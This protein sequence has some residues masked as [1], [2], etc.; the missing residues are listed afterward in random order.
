MEI[1]VLVTS[2]RTV[3]QGR[4][5]E[6]GKDSEDYL[7]N[8]ALIELSEEDLKK[9]GIEEGSCVRVE[10]KWGSIVVRCKSSKNLPEGVAFMPYGP[11][12]SAIAD[13][14]TFGV[15]IPY[16]KQ[17]ECTVSPAPGEKVPSLKELA[18]M[19]RG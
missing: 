11:W 14:E 18:E 10:S 13:P 15:G 5:L 9:L 3:G 12:L 4:G 8:V 6:R 7:K 19:L 1:R 17:L 2:G 16:L